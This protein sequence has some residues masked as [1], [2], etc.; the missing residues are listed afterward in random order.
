MENVP[1]VLNHGGDNVAEHICDSLEELGYSCSYTLLN[2]V[3]YGVPQMRERMFLVAY[4]KDLGVQK[5][6]WPA[7]THAHELPRG[8]GGT[9]ACAL[10]TVNNLSTKSRYKDP[11]KAGNDLPPAVT[12]EQALSDLPK[13]HAIELLQKREISRG[14]RPLHRRVDYPSEPQHPYACQ[15][16]QWP[17]IRTSRRN[18]AAAVTGHE[19]RYLPRDYRIFACMA[20][21][22]QYPEA[23]QRALQMF[24]Q[25]LGKR[26]PDLTPDSPRYKAL[27]DDFV[28]PYD[29]NKFPNKWRKMEPDAPART[30][31]AHLGK[32]SYSHIHY[33]SKQ[34]RTISVREAARLQS[35]P[36]GFEFCGSMNAGFRQIGNAVPPLLAYA[37]AREISKQLGHTPRRDFRK[38]SKP[39][40]AGTSS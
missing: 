22:D 24:K 31:M 25:E 20:P 37:L 21:G 2:A 23:H 33:D 40:K 5:I 6:Q 30:L 15:M 27:H 1:D 9:R 10:R 4:R 13:I 7:P 29:P 26:S 32:D 12:A 16:R 28:P 18:Q 14:A 19:I 8:Y 39:K 17:R 38:R 11:P 35:F 36:D 34:A 3:H